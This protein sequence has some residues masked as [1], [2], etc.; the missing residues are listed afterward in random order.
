MADTSDR[1]IPAT[2]RRREAA[3]QQG[4]MPLSSLPAW[5]AAV[6]TALA[7]APAWSAATL[8]A[9]ADML[10]AALT[11][12][13]DEKAFDPAA[14]VDIRLFLPTIAV[15]AASGAVGI[16]VR[17]L[18]DGAAWR[19]ARIMPSWQRIDPVAGL[20]RIFSLT[21]L[22]A[23]ATNAIASSVLAAAAVWSIAPLFSVADVADLVADPAR[24]VARGQRAILPLAAVAAVVAAV[25]WGLARRR[26][27]AR[28]R[29]TPQEY[30]D[31]AKSMQA[32]PKVRLMREQARQ[33]HTHSGR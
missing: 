16:A 31:E 8:P 13:G 2:P 6:L 21:T 32:D 26:F 24:L 23:L 18:L 30:Q 27:E 12:A 20:A 7:L 25:Q 9:A 28:I 17:V 22:T 3:R 19:T 4:M 1:T 10:R 11:A 14:L 33:A 5:L 15:I 29:M